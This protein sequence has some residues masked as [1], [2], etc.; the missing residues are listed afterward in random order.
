MAR[1]KEDGTEVTEGAEGAPAKAKKSRNSISFAAPD[2]LRERLEQE[3]AANGGVSVRV[4]VRDLLAKQ[5]G[6]V[7][8]APRTRSTYGTPEEKKVA[9]KQ[10]RMDR[11]ALIKQLMAEHQAK[12]SGVVAAVATPT[13]AETVSA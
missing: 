13:E 1:T 6:L 11:A 12:I 2:N 9:S 8:P 5:F 10:R 3:A 7:L 4:Y